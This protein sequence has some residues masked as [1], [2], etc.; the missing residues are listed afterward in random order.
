MIWY[1]SEYFHYDQINQKKFFIILNEKEKEL[2]ELNS[3]L[4]N[5]LSL[6]EKK[7]LDEKSIY[8]KISTVHTPFITALD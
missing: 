5:L 4:N 7:V 8:S 3:W 2:N 1:F 6:K